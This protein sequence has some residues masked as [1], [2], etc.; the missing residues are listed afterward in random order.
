MLVQLRIFKHIGTSEHS[1]YIPTAGG[2]HRILQ[3]HGRTQGGIGVADLVWPQVSG[4]L[5]KVMGSRFD[6]LAVRRRLAN[7]WLVSG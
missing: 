2:V 7:R 4:A 3:P 5:T 1:R 6:C